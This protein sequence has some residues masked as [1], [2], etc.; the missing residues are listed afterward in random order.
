MSEASPFKKPRLPP[1]I[2]AKPKNRCK[3]NYLPNEDDEDDADS[4][5]MENQNID[6]ASNRAISMADSSN[7]DDLLEEYFSYS[8]FDSSIATQAQSQLSQI[9]AQVGQ[10]TYHPY[11]VDEEYEDFNGVNQKETQMRQPFRVLGVCQDGPFF[12]SLKEILMQRQFQL[13]SKN[14]TESNYH[15]IQHSVRNVDF[16]RLFL[17]EYPKLA[18]QQIEFTSSYLRFAR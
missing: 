17:R 18:G 10:F 8:N 11:F 14:I 1:P 15:F 2:Q 3:I 16:L 13:L 9:F 4:V 6:F 7:D 5:N 12:H